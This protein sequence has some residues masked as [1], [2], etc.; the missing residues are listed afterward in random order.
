MQEDILKCLLVNGGV[1]MG[2]ED[3]YKR[4]VVLLSQNRDLQK[5]IISISRQL[6]SLIKEIKELRY[7]IDRK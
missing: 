7:S 5:A 1:V 2:L 3:N 6:P 4:A